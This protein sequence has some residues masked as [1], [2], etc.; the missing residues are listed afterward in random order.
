M[1]GRSNI[2]TTALGLLLCACPAPDYTALGDA[3][4]VTVDGYDGDVMEPFISRD[5]ARLYFNNSNSPDVDTNLHVATRV[6]DDHFTYVGELSGANTGKLDAVATADTS[7]RFYFVTLR[8]F[9]DDQTT[10][11]TG[12]LN[13]NALE[14]VTSV[15]GVATRVPLMVDFD[16]ESSFD[17]NTLWVAHGRF[18]PGFPWPTSGDVVELRRNGD[19]FERANPDTL[20]AVNSSALEYAACSSP[21]ALELVCTRVARAPGAEPSIVRAARSRV[22]APFEAPQK[23]TAATGFVEGPALT[24]DGRSLYFHKKDGERYVLFRASR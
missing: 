8:S 21:D 11:Y 7:G 1:A 15:A 19:S 18:V 6:D 5:V 14:Q 23:V 12:R 3:H 4:R 13:G 2:L 24:P 10:V 17:G 20:D 9:D 22:D 16:V